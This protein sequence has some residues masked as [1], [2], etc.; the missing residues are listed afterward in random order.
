MAIADAEVKIPVIHNMVFT[1]E[2][3]DEKV[4]DDP[5]GRTNRDLMVL[6]G[7]LFLDSVESI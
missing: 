6:V 4:E 7:A 2:W 1:Q 5:N 3:L